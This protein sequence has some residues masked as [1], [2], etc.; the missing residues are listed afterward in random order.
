M[1]E[2]TAKEWEYFLLNFTD[3]HILQTRQWGDLKARFGWQ[4]VRVIA[5]ATHN[6]ARGQVGAQILFRKLPFGFSIGYIPKG[7][8]GQAEPQGNEVLWPA[9]WTEIDLLSQQRHAVFLKVEPDLIEPE[10]KSLEISDLDVG[11]SLPGFYPSQHSIQPRRT[12][13]VDISDDEGEILQRMKQKTRYN[14]RL[15]QKR[16]ILVSTCSDLGTFFRLLQA[17]GS[18]DGFSVHSQAYYQ[19]AYDLFHPLGLCEIFQANHNGEPIACLMV[20]ARGH[21][22]WYFYGGS[23]DVH[24]DLM[25]SYL[26]QWEAMRW[27]KSRGCQAYDMWGVPDFSLDILESQFT[28]RSDGLWGVYRFKR[29]FGGELKR[30]EGPQDR[31]YHPLLYR[32]YRLWMRYGASKNLNIG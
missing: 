20:F 1:P 26:L 21:R 9:L 19:F 7:P 25:P 2:I 3:A 12:L 23:A 6:N 24:R 8:I 15:A 10:T 27:A 32:A 31:V 16:G 22:A 30:S 17:T 13:L 11:F 14:I 28:H 18:R 4:V 5:N 29:G